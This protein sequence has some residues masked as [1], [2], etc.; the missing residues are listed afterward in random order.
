VI[1]SVSGKRPS[2]AAVNEPLSAALDEG[3]PA[4]GAAV[5]LK[6]FTSPTPDNADTPSETIC[7]A[8]LS[9]RAA[10]P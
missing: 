7:A 9:G 2:V 3:V 1:I 10:Y 8:K 6:E 5:L 4:G